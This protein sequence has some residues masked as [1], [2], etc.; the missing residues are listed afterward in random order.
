VRKPGPNPGFF[1]ISVLGLEE[2]QI[3][4]EVKMTLPRSTGFAPKILF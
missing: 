2:R 4:Q 3:P 1:F